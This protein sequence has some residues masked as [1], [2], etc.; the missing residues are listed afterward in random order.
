MI[1][2]L[3]VL[4]FKMGRVVQRQTSEA[5]SFPDYYY[6]SMTSNAGSQIVT[7]TVTQGAP[8]ATSGASLITTAPASSSEVLVYIYPT[9]VTE[10][11][12]PTSSSSSDHVSGLSPGVIA[13]IVI[14]SLA[15]LIILILTVFCTSRIFARRKRQESSLYT[16]NASRV[17]S[18]QHQPKSVQSRDPPHELAT[19]YNQ[20]E[21]GGRGRPFEMVGSHLH[22]AELQAGN[23]TDL[24][25]HL[26]KIPPDGG[27]LSASGHEKGAVSDGRGSGEC[28]SPG[29]ETVSSDCV[30]GNT[31]AR[32]STT[33]LQA[34]SSDRS[35]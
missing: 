8:T 14:G 17:P 12:S 35:N 9:S 26:W 23:T 21:M 18:Y 11:S 32:L 34:S 29:W 6:T 25:T 16:A 3:R 15:F 24:P 31:Q 2:S 7:V 33:T 28:L 5:T 10:S 4:R 19:Q 20:L 30:S 1:S 22:P 27:Y 13:G